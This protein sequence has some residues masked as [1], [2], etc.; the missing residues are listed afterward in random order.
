[1]AAM[2]VAAVGLWGSRPVFWPLPSLFLLGSSAASG[3]GFINGV[4]NLGGFAGPYVVG[5]LKDATGSFAWALY[6]LAGSSLL[7]AV[8]AFIFVRFD[9]PAPDASLPPTSPP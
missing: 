6:F 5:L 4:G 8:M 9:K 2:A 7:G 1:M 3:I